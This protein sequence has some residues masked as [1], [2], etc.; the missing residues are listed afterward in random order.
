MATR[1]LPPVVGTAATDTPATATVAAYPGPVVVE[2]AVLL[3]CEDEDDDVEEE[4]EDT[5]TVDRVVALAESENVLDWV[6]VEEGVELAAVEEED[7][8]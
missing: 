7:E 5:T 3:D 1:V 6:E 4:E 8:E 2:V